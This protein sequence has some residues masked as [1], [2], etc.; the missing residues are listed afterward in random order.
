[1]SYSRSSIVRVSE[2]ELPFWHVNG[3]ASGN[4]T[5]SVSV[6]H[7]MNVF[8]T[9]AALDFIV[10]LTKPQPRDFECTLTVVY[11]VTDEV[12][13]GAGTWTLEANDGDG[14]TTTLAT[15]TGTGTTIATHTVVFNFN[16]VPNTALGTSLKI[17]QIDGGVGA[18]S[19]LA[20]YSF[21]WQAKRQIEF[22]K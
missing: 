15:G 11:K 14:S 12:L 19:Q 5:S 3:Q 9:A 20:V 2:Y 4:A 1:M 6:T 10:L 7:I 22:V 18:A 21:R 16:T 17:S 13:D 8:V